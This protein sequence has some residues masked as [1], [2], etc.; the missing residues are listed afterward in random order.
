ML[1]LVK[2]LQTSTLTWSYV[3]IDK[4]SLKKSFDSI[5]L[6]LCC[7]IDD[8]TDLE[9]EIDTIRKKLWALEI[10]L[11]NGDYYIQQHQGV[12]ND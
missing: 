2:L 4:E 11:L 10:A 6:D 7:I 12:N 5:D 3:V 1:T 9:D 8:P